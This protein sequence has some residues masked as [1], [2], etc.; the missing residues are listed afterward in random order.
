M[1]QFNDFFELYHLCV[2]ILG[3]CKVLCTYCDDCLIGDPYEFLEHYN[4]HCEKGNDQNEIT[5][6]CKIDDLSDEEAINEVALK[7]DEDFDI[8]KR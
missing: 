1:D 7:V 8:N 2:Y 4:K 6:Y 3:W 5:N